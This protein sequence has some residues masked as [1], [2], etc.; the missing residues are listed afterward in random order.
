MIQDTPFQQ[1]IGPRLEV[2]P[3][4]IWTQI[5]TLDPAS[6]PVAR[7]AGRL[8]YRGPDEAKAENFEPVPAMRL[9]GTDEHIWGRKWEQAWWTVQVPPATDKRR[10]WLVWQDRAEATVYRPDGDTYTPHFGIDPGHH[11]APLPDGFE[12]GGTLMVESVCCRTGIWVAGETQG[13]D[14]R[15][16]IFR[17]AY[18]AT[19]NEAAWQL[20]HDVDVLL[21]VAKLLSRTVKPEPAPATAHGGGLWDVNGYRSPID[22]APPLLR[23]L[24]HE[25]NRVQIAFERD[26]V[27]AAAELSKQLLASLPAEA[28]A[29]RAT[30]TGHCHIDLVWLWP[31]RVGELKAVHSFATADTLMEEYPELTFGY[32]Q[33]ASYEA[34]ERRA[35]SLMRRVRGRIA[36]KR[37]DATGAL[38]VESDSQI[39]CGEALL[40]SFE[41]GQVG[42]RDLTG[43][44]SA[45]VWLP[46]AFGYSGCLPQLMAG[47]GVTDFFTTKLHWSN[48]TQFPHSAFRWQGHDGSSVNAFIAWEHYNL[49]VKPSELAYACENQRQ[50]AVFNETLTPTGFGDGGGGPTATMLERARRV[51]D[52]ATMPRTSWGRVDDFFD[53]LRPHANDLPT[54]RGEMYLEFHRAVQ[55]TQ[56]ALKA[57]YR[58]GERALQQHEAAAAL[59]LTSAPDTHAWKRLVFTQFHDYLTGTSVQE[60]YDEGLPELEALADEAEQAALKGVGGAGNSHVFNPLPCERIERVGDQLLRVPPL[61]V[62]AVDSL[63]S[64][65]CNDVAGDDRSLD[66]GRVEAKFDDCGGLVGLAIDGVS[67]RLSGACRL[68]WFPDDPTTYPAWDTDRPSIAMAKAVDAATASRSGGDAGERWVAFDHDL[69]DCGMATVTFRLPAGSPAL[70]VEVNVDWKRPSTTLLW[71]LPTGYDLEPA[72]Y[73]MPFGS[74]ARTQLDNTAADDAKFEVPLSRWMSV[75]DSAGTGVA[76]ISEAKYGGGVRRGLM[77]LTLLRS[78]YVTGA[79]DN[80]DLRDF[81]HFGGDGTH[82]RYWDIGKSRVCFALTR[83][84]HDLPRHEQPAALAESLYTPMLSCN[85]PVADAGFL[86]IDGCT[87]LLPTWAKPTDKGW[88]LRLNETAGRH[89]TATLRLASGVRATPT[90]LRGEPASGAFDGTIHVTPHAL[91]TF[92]LARMK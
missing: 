61:A 60:V 77:H 69:G 32:S 88:L 38:Y 40:R 72:R 92:H 52:L 68:A 43:S 51:A 50:A 62:A 46:D 16:S 20:W 12:Q 70:R 23:R 81:A 34:V 7:S 73:G 56:H 9:G 27:D 4:R 10:R 5:W 8:D 3:G 15:G 74:T 65:A 26:G 48:A 2:L 85:G 84:A 33:T 30:L 13:I 29:M 83:A 75:G 37:W 54:W 91:L 78:P 76:L 14:D 90:D 45:T 1:F 58:R 24:L 53:R 49:A 35:P 6:L 80:P 39:P 17:G 19:R 47:F 36:E 67:I 25:L 42:F 31:E 57:I 71:T 22:Q 63:E 66:N 64:V 21:G 79:D 44:D 18:L 41:L 86:G 87:S 82:V 89:G 11:E 55:T 28:H 59:G